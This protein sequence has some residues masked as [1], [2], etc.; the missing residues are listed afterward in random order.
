MTGED[1]GPVPR[2]PC[3]LMCRASA[4]SRR[5]K[6][7]SDWPQGQGGDRRAAGETREHRAAGRVPS[8]TSR[9]PAQPAAAPATAQPAPQRALTLAVGAPPARRALLASPAPAA[10]S[11]GAHGEQVRRRESPLPDAAPLRGVGR[12][13]QLC[14]PA[15]GD[16]AAPRP[17]PGLP[18]AVAVAG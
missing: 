8:V 10:P 7:R 3:H 14:P 9:L 17:R 16:P 2:V 11:S 18:S 15:A 1:T 5:F 12:C 6:L 13:R 4:S